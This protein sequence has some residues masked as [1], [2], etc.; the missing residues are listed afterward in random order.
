LLSYAQNSKK[1]VIAAAAIH[2]KDIE[3]ADQPN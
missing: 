1:T 2:K 3:V